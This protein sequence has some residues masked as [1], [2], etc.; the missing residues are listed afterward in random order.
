ME[1]GN[2]DI[3]CGI[4]LHHRKQGNACENDSHTNTSIMRLNICIFNRGISQQQRVQ[5]YNAV[6]FFSGVVII[7]HDRIITKEKFYQNI[8]F[9]N[10]PAMISIFTIERHHE[11]HSKNHHEDNYLRAFSEYISNTKHLN[12]SRFHRE[13]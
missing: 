13:E 1:Q 5:V 7:M 10:H 4:M 2:D 11:W 8:S 12:N 9:V 3:I 6:K